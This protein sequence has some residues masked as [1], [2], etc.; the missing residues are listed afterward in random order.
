MELRISK[1]MEGGDF[2]K[3]HGI[4]SML[5]VDGDEDVCVN[6]QN[7]MVGTSVY[8]QYALDGYTAL[9]MIEKKMLQN[10]DYSL[11]LLAWKLPEMDGIETA[12]R[13]RGQVGNQIPILVLTE[14]DWSEVEE[15]AKQAGINAFL[16]K[17]FFISNFRQVVEQLH[18]GEEYGEEDNGKPKERKNPYPS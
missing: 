15:D 1:Q 6:I 11:I 16:Q 18:S 3:K 7:L 10:S 9:K 13:I 2:W 14:Y 5:V 12:K 17:P 4:Y 8:V